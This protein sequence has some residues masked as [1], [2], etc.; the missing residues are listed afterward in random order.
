MSG[1]LFLL[2]FSLLFSGQATLVE[3][4]QRAFDAGR[5]REAA[6]LFEKGLGAAPDCRVL[7][8]LGMARFRQGAGD[9]AI[10]NFRG[11]AECDP[12]NVKTRAALAE[13]Y[14]SKG[15]DNQALAEYEAALEH[16]AGYTSALRGAGRLYLRHQL[17]EKAVTVL[18]R[19]AAHEPGA[20]QARAD[21]GAAY[22]GT[23][24]LD[25]AEQ[26]FQAALKIDPENSSA[27]TGLG[28]VYVKTSRA[29]QAVEVLRR[30]TRR[31]SE[32]YEPYFLLGAAYSALNQPEAAVAALEEARRRAGREPEIH[33]RLALAYGRTGRAADRDREL[34]TFRS[35]KK[36][37][38]DAAEA[39]REAARLTEQ[40]GEL[41]NAGDLTSALGVLEKARRLDPANER[42]LFRL[43]GVQ[44]DLKQFE[45]ARETVTEAIRHVPSEWSYYYLLGLT[46]KATN[47]LVDARQNLELAVRLNPRAADVFNQLGDVAMRQGDAPRAVKYFSRAAEL[48]TAE[49]A[50]QSNLR[51][52]RRAAGIN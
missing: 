45:R 28:H 51:A 49:P 10:L 13:A 8:F 32:A 11:A 18:E 21:L 27:L 34:A 36:A 6:D 16:D 19:L 17:N 29:P 15:F 2:Y 25:K 37:A 42:V 46:D 52:A 24:H 4:G 35:L 5:Y 30:A 26:E 23:N 22:A 31:S 44:F 20:A 41:I 7:F 1:G 12:R 14:E 38:E 47:R 43:A 40:A 9:A 48:D 50:Y 39:G 33:Y 3:Q